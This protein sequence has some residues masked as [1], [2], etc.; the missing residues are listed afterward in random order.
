MRFRDTS[1]EITAPAASLQLFIYCLKEK[2]FFVL[3]FCF[4][5]NTHIISYYIARYNIFI[6]VLKRG[7]NNLLSQLHNVKKKNTNIIIITIIICTRTNYYYSVV[8]PSYNINII[9]HSVA[10]FTDEKPAGR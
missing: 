5:N 9:Q 3:F 10:S 4:H 1:F 8:K 6:T 2:R 7:E